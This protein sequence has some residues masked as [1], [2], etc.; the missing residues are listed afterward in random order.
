M[1]RALM[2]MLVMSIIFIMADVSQ[3]VAVANVSDN[4]PEQ[5]AMKSLTQPGSTG[6]PSWE[7]LRRMTN[8]EK[9]NAI[10]QIELGQDVTVAVKTTV[11][12]VENLWNSGQFEDALNGFEQLSQINGVGPIAIGVGWRNPIPT[13]QT[14]LWGADV[15]IG[16][17]DSIYINCLD[18]HRASGKLFAILTYT[19]GGGGYWSVNLSIDGGVSWNE[20]YVWFA[21][22]GE[23]AVSVS[24]SVLGNY[25]YVAYRTSDFP[26]EARLRRFYV[27]NGL[28]Y[29]AYSTIYSTVTPDTI[30]EV[31]ITSNQDYY[32]DR[33]Y[34]F[35]LAKNGD[36]RLFWDDT[37]A[38]SWLEI[39]TG[40]TDA[41]RGLDATCNEGY[42]TRYLWVTYIDMND[43][44]NI[45]YLSSG[46]IYG[47]A[48]KLYVGSALMNPSLAAYHDTLI[49]FHEMQGSSVYHCR[50]EVSYSGGSSWLYGGV[51]DTVTNV[52]YYPDVTARKGGGFGVVYRYYSATRELRFVHRGYASVPSWSAPISIADNQPNTSS[53]AIEYIGGGTYGT[54]YSSWL[55]PYREAYFDRSSPYC[56]YLPGDI[57]G[58]GVRIG[59]DV[60]Y[61]VRYFKGVGGPPPDSCYMD[62]IS[63]YLYVAGD[64]NGNCEFRGSDITRLVSFFKGTA[65]LSTC[66]F[67]PGPPLRD[68]H[69][70]KLPE[71]VLDR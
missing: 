64:V 70:Y 40:V 31:A 62:S 11:T 57:N 69:R 45:D 17:R 44:L 33:I 4:L 51:D 22:S 5:A 9:A 50:Y 52:S 15:R 65:V 59:G 53:P 19:E 10:I 37:T 2:M 38:T 27:I 32:N 71:E 21:G 26:F 16:N 14:A 29:P 66:H 55:S 63:D 67:F 7:F 12:Q 39:S 54:V 42:A 30:R 49:C 18:I 1:R 6:E 13:N 25:C 24:A 60:T 35:G 36:L 3:A 47:N 68:N 20:T 56:E 34:Y 23:Q 61:G 48:K 28:A 58:D 46:S 8:T 43:T 41:E